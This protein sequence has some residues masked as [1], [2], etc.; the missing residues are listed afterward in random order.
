MGSNYILEESIGYIVRN[1]TKSLRTRILENLKKAGIEIN[2]EEWI[3]LA[4]LNRYD[5][6]NQ[7]QL[8]S[9]LMQDKTAVTRLVDLM[10]RNGLVRRKIDPKDKRNKIILLTN[11]GRELYEKIVPYVEK[12]IDQANKG[13]NDADLEL[14]KSTL[15]KM[16]S[17][18]SI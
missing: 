11:E 12:T 3:A 5:D 2:I 7:Q 16:N 4:F 18:L 6:K 1:F 15:I 8:G 14:V 9:L 17:N 10:E 13:I